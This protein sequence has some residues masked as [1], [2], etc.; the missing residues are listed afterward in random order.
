MGKLEDLE[1]LQKLRVEGALTEEEFKIEKEKILNLKNKNKQTKMIKSRLLFVLTAIF[2]LITIGCF[3]YKSQCEERFDD[4]IAEHMTD[5]IALK[6]KTITQA[7]YDSIQKKE[8]NLRHKMN[9]SAIICTISAGITGVLFI[10][11]T[12]LK[13]VEV[14]KEK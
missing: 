14:R 11:G 13:I 9:T 5:D 4:Y 7:E 1:K 3:I 2:I 12:V 8:D 10:T 6:W